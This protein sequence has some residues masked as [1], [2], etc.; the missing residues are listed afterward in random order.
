[1]FL[2]CAPF[3]GLGTHDEFKRATGDDVAI[4]DVALVIAL[5]VQSGTLHVD[6]LVTVVDGLDDERL[7]VAY[8]ETC[9][10][11]LG[12]TDDV[13]AACGL[14]L[15]QA[16]RRQHIPCRPLA[17]VL[18][19]A[20]AVKVVA[21]LFTQHAADELSRFL[22]LSHVIIHIDDVVAGLVTVGIL[23]DQATHVR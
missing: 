11:E 10:V 8:I 15:I 6:I 19:A 22:G 16:D 5:A 3:R 20:Q 17:H 18:V 13:L 2:G 14:F 9:L 7:A 1:M 4:V 23:A 12:R 21:V